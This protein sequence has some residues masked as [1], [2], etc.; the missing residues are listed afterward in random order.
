MPSGV[1]GLLESGHRLLAAHGQEVLE[2]LRE[3][4]ASFEIVEERLE[5]HA[6]ADEDGRAP[7]KS[8]SL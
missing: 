4:I 5:R 7:E 1:L 3:R 6:G 2:K 8:G